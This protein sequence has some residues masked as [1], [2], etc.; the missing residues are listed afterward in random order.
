MTAPGDAWPIVSN[1]TDAERIDAMHVGG[2]CGVR[3]PIKTYCRTVRLSNLS[4]D[5]GCAPR[6]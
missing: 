4:A 1:Y 5:D 2:A 3:D 6:S